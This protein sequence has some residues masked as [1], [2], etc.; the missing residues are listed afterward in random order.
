VEDDE[1]VRTFVRDTLEA[2]GYT[3]LTVADGHEAVEVSEH[4]P[5]TINL[6][7]TDVIMPHLGGREVA[8]VIVKK[9]ADIRVLFMSGYTDDMVL[10]HGVAEG[11]K[12]FLAKP[13]TAPR[14]LG[15]IRKVLAD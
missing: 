13:F 10:A 14:L 8:D 12:S 2:S 9:R 11:N 6:L 1:A 3:V 15:R 5:K 4:Y 7:L